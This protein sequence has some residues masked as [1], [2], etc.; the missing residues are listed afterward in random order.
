MTLDW[1]GIIRHHGMEKIP[2]EWIG[3]YKTVNPGIILWAAMLASENTRNENGKEWRESLRFWTPLGAL[4]LHAK[5]AWR[6]ERRPSDI[7]P[8]S[9]IEGSACVF[10][11]TDAQ[12]CHYI[13]SNTLTLLH[14]R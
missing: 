1:K 2:S 3:F 6:W 13:T 7:R 11:L 12:G 4:R 14:T 8:Q 5:N 10:P 9:K